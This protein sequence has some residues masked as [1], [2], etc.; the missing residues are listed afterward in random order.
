MIEHVILNF[1]FGMGPGCAI[2][3]RHSL[4]VLNRGL[5]SS[6]YTIHVVESNASIWQDGYLG[7]E[8]VFERDMLVKKVT[9]TAEA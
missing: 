7:M 5:P 1:L 3:R 6:Y 9:R 4:R 8:I 2:G